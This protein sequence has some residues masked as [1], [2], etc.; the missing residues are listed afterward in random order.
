MTGQQHL[1]LPYSLTDPSLVGKKATLVFYCFIIFLVVDASSSS[2]SPS[3]VHEYQSLVGDTVYLPCNVSH[4]TSSSSPS[5]SSSS[6]SLPSGSS[7]SYS[8][9]TSTPRSDFPSVVSSSPSGPVS[10]KDMTPVS[11][12]LWFKD[13]ISSDTPIYTLDVRNQGSLSRSRHISSSSLKDRAHFDVSLYPPRLVI[14]NITKSDQG[15]FRCR[16]RNEN[17]TSVW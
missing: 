14:N 15:L 9:F 11:L 4:W 1:T 7:A 13:Q 5:S 3:S 16:V 12:V 17:K 6:S 10:K 8:F 2:S